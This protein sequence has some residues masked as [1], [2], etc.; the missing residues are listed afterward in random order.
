MSNANQNSFAEGDI[1]E[2]PAEYFDDDDGLVAG[3]NPVVCAGVWGFV[4]NVHVLVILW[5]FRRHQQP[6]HFV[7]EPTTCCIVR[8]L[9][10]AFVDDSVPHCC[11]YMRVYRCFE[12]KCAVSCSCYRVND[13][14]NAQLFAWH[15]HRWT[16]SDYVYSVCVQLWEDLGVFEGLWRDPTNSLELHPYVQAHCHGHRKPN[17]K[18]NTQGFRGNFFVRVIPTEV[19][20]TDKC[21]NSSFELR[22]ECKS[23]DH[24]AHVRLVKNVLVR[25]NEHSG[26][27]LTLILQ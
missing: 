15:I 12:A 19:L 5:D 27:V 2:V 11:A 4:Y 14:G 13:F 24:V 10:I 20:S 16:G 1:V 17:P 26:L 8:R 22:V 7:L 23:G 9:F 18:S 21:T 25:E 6:G 3:K